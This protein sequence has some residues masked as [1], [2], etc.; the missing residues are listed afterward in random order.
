MWA[1]V[2][3]LCANELPRDQCNAETAVQVTQ[4]VE[5]FSMPIGCA[6][7]SMRLLPLWEDADDTTHAVV[8]CKH[9]GT[10]Q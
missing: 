6:V 8:Q 10:N 5:S 9:I 2:V 3:F 7:A 1:L 4:P